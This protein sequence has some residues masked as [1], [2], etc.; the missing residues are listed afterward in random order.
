MKLNQFFI[1]IMAAGMFCACSEDGNAPEP[2][3]NGFNGDGYIAINIQLPSTAIDSRALNDDFDDGT[4]SEYDVKSAALILFTGSDEMNAQFHSAYD[5]GTLDKNEDLDNDNITT[6]FLKAVKVNKIQTGDNVKLYGL[7]MLNYEGIVNV[8][9]NTLSI[10]N[11]NFTGTFNDFLNKTSDKAFYTNGTEGAGNFFMTNAPLSSVAGGSSEPESSKISTLAVL[12]GGLKATEAE[13]K[14]SPAGSVYVERAVAKATISG[15]PTKATIGEGEN[16]IELA[17]ESIEWSLSNIEPTSYIV[18]NLGDASF[19]N[20]ISSKRNDYRF[21]GSK[22]MD[23]TSIQTAMDLFRTYWCIDP[24]YQTDKTYDNATNFVATNVPLYCHENTFDVEHQNY[25]NTTRAVFKVVYKVDGK[26]QDFYTVNDIQ[27]VIYTDAETAESQSVAFICRS[28]DVQNAIKNALNPGQD[29]KVKDY[30]TVTFT[31]D[32]NKIHQAS[33][34]AFNVPDTKI[35][36]GK[37]FAKKPVLDQDVVDALIVSVNKYFRIA[38]YEGGVN[39]YDLRFMHFASD[40]DSHDLAP[41]SSDKATT[42]STAEAYPQFNAADYLGRYGMVRNNWYDVT[43]TAI[44]HLGSPV[45]PNANVKT[46]D[47]NKQDKQW[48]SFKIN[49]LSW[50]KRTQSHEF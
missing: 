49:I 44:S 13:A 24:A 9:E 15:V 18:R 10:D 46:P 30:V 6:S 43:L 31:T 2:P 33:D 3:V 14:A 36:A 4:P 41:W 28:A 19:I 42:E 32:E 23:E 22:K 48:I 39:Y 7:V 8:N 21:V 47:D 16:K 38:K 26:T 29:V 35:G 37:E 50:A 34:I 40:K 20:L 27:N 11:T 5:L 45:I 25:R 12:S 17:I 1:G